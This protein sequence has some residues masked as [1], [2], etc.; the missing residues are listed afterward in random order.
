MNYD[1]EKNPA[2]LISV[3]P[4]YPDR[5]LPVPRYSFLLCICR[6]CFKR[7]KAEKIIFGKRLFDISLVKGRQ[8]P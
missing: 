2:V 1:R 3:R 7:R 8:S 6:H 4:I 5:S